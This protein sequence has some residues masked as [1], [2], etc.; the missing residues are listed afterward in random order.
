MTNFF[1]AAIEILVAL[2]SVIQRNGLH[3]D[4]FAMWIPSWRMAYHWDTAHPI[5]SEAPPVH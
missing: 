3:G 1:A 5:G 4:A 2:G